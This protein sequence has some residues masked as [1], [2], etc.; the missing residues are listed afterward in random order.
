MIDDDSI[1]R[2]WYQATTNKQTTPLPGMTDKVFTAKSY[3]TT[4]KSFTDTKL[5]D[6]CIIAL[7]PSVLKV[8]INDDA[9]HLHLILIAQSIIYAY[10]I[11]KLK[12][13]IVRGRWQNICQVRFLPFGVQIEENTLFEGEKKNTA[14]AHPNKV[15]RLIPWEDVLDVIVTEVVLSYKVFSMVA[16][17]IDKEEGTDKKSY[18]DRINHASLVPAFDPNKVSMTYKEC[19]LM[20]K[21][22]S[23]EIGKR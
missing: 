8:L 6:L 23:D 3:L 19:L 1:P 13:I 4:Q 22:M 12:S 9:E 17:R 14:M 15:L 2:C 5:L 10:C 21:E 20:W 11:A 18:Q 16:F 7:L